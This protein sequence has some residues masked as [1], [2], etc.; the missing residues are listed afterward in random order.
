VTKSNKDS[1]IKSDSWTLVRGA[2]QLLTL[3]SRNGARRGVELGDLGIITDGSVLLRN[4]FIESAGPTRRIENMAGARMADEIDAAGRVLMPAFIDPD[5]C[6]VPVPG[7]RGAVSTPVHRLPASRLEAQADELLKLMA[8]HG[9]ATVGALSGY[10]GDIPGELK[11]LRTLNARNQKPLDVVSIHYIRSLPVPGQ[12]SIPEFSQPEAELQ[13]SHPGRAGEDLLHCVSRRKLASITALRCGEGGVP[14]PDAVAL[15]TAAQ[16]LGFSV[17]LQVPPGHDDQL[18]ETA[19][20]FRALSI[21][22]PGPYRASEI[23]ILA[24]SATFAILLPQL[25]Y[26]AGLASSARELIDNGALI[27]LGTGLAPDGGTASM[28]SVIQLACGMF[29]LSLPEAISAATINA[30]WS[31]GLGSQT[32]SLEHGK[33]GDLILLN[34]SDYRELQMLSATNLTHSLIKRGVVLCKED[35]PGWPSLT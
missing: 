23:E 9:T 12:E 5:A 29:G 17:R 3:H 10:G 13:A 26:R 6:L 1:R 11:I 19:I 2:K 24:E 30:A 34:A 15:W 7:C 21:S 31:L 16:S 20:D 28:Q 35:F 18:V 27:A 32:G 14:L 25:L 22:R 8:Q 4:G 33:R